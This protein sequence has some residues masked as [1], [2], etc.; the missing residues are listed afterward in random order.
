MKKLIA[1]FVTGV[2]VLAG[3]GGGGATDGT[4]GDLPDTRPSAV[5]SGTAFDGLIINGT[6]NIYDWSTGKKGALLASGQTDG[7][8]L[9]SISISTPDKPILVEVTNGYYIE[10]ASGVQIQLK[11]D[12]GQKL[13]A[14]TYYR[15]GVPV[16]IS[17]TF[18]T[19]IATGYAEYLVSQGMSPT[20]A[21]VNSNSEISQWAGFDIET[22]TPLDAANV[23]NASPVL[24]D[25]LRYGLVA[26]GISELTKQIHI[27]LG[28]QPHATWPS[29]HIIGLAYDDVRAD[30]LLDG[31][32]NGGQPLA[33]GNL[34][35]N[36]DTF[37]AT[38][39]DYILRFVAR[40]SRNATGLI[41]DDVRDFALA[42]NKYVSAVFGNTSPGTDISQ[43]FPS[44]QQF[45][46]EE[47][48][49]VS[50]TFPVNAM[51]NDPH[52]IAQVEY[53]VDGQFVATAG[54]PENP[55]QSIVTTNFSNGA[56][57][58]EIRVTNVWGNTTTVVNN[59]TIANSGPQISLLTRY[60]K[61]NAADHKCDFSL[62]IT[63][64]TGT[65]LSS[66]KY[67][68]YG[69]SYNDGHLFLEDSRNILLGGLSSYS[70]LDFLT[71][72]HDFDISQNDIER[73]LVVTS[74]NNAG[75]TT[76]LHKYVNS[77]CVVRDI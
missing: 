36:I 6:V 24:T 19:T 28:Q 4:T 23:S 9:Y 2:L 12:Q 22:T 47:G 68:V 48:T 3:C 18:F 16:T 67:E 1:F 63:D 76:I 53:Y 37:R 5:V 61:I 25:G 8:G 21:V 51:V 39:A 35:L 62:N 52:G 13:L 60:T 50:G 49:I 73:D 69:Y 54:D 10:E 70:L 20:N 11:P 38:L 71:L 14:V 66:V 45:T 44:V 15:S 26:A 34:A 32:G 77:S 40:N 65:G 57:Q 30:G 74:V 56:H 64:D 43:S 33:V 75:I 7:Q 27:D 29:V 17:A 42:L 58:F 46:P 59:I 55:A 31:R 41:F 72:V